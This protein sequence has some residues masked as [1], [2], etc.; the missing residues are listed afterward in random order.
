M[1]PVPTAIWHEP[2]S[3]RHQGQ[4]GDR[5]GQQEL[6]AGLGPTDVTCLTNAELHQPRQP[7]L[8]NLP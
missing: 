2:D 6:A 3:G 5:G 7:M 4:I 8:S 1:P